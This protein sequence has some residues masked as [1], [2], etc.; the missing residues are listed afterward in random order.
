MNLKLI[1]NTFK[2]NSD[3]CIASGMIY[4]PEEITPSTSEYTYAYQHPISMN[5]LSEEE[6]IEYM[7]LKYE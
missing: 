3:R 4:Y 2:H 6:A 5:W 7:R 1:K